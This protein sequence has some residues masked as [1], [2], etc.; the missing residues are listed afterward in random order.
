MGNMPD[1]GDHDDVENKDQDEEIMNDSPTSV[2]ES[3]LPALFCMAAAEGNVKQ[4]INILK[5]FPG[6]HADSVDYDFRSAAHVAAAEGQ[7]V[8]I[9]FL[10][11]HSNSK[12]QNLHWMN[13]E[14][15]WGR[16]PIEEAY[17]HRHYAVADYLRERKMTSSKSILSEIDPNQLV[18]TNLIVATMSKWK[19][20]L[21]FGT[22]ASKNEAELINGLLGSGVF[23]SSE[24]YADYDGRTPM[25]LAASNGQLDVVKVLQ[26]YGDDGRTYKDR[27]G[28]CAI[29]EARRKKFVQI[30][31]VLLNDI[32]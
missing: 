20:I 18:T 31:D 11:E 5:Q 28:N 1:V 13:R 2:E 6:F 26:Y 14:D 23:S 17:H 10:C 12:K 29:D 16:T 25:H 21:Y 27:W 30:V 22:L 19:K 7:L 3:L 8:S 15:R 32:V 24:L 9:Q 4:M